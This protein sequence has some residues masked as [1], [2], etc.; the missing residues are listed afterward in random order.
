MKTIKSVLRKYPLVFQILKFLFR[1]HIGPLFVYDRVH[2]FIAKALGLPYFGGVLKAGQLSKYRVKPM[3]T[4]AR[5]LEANKDIIEVGSW[6]GQSARLWAAEVG[7]G[8][9]TCIDHWQGAESSPDSMNEATQN[10][11]I[12]KLFL[13]NTQEYRSKIRI[14]PRSS[15]VAIEL[16][17]DNK[18][19]IVYI[20]GDHEYTQV[21]KDIENY[22]ELVR[23]GGYICGDDLELYPS[24]IDKKY[25]DE[26]IHADMIVDPVLGEAYHPGVNRA[27]EEVFGDVNMKN[28]FWWKKLSTDNRK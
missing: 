10:D 20:D 7:N 4:L 28:G 26:N 21:K 8:T 27:V 19:D 24:Q 12:Y 22:K 1:L 14:I 17:K 18:Y 23:E 5:S 13:H 25:R 2:Y 9:L 15:D 16:V 6:A 3:K 11:E